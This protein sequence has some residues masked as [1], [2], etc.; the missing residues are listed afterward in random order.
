MFFRDDVRQNDI[1]SLL[2]L[3]KEK[4]IFCSLCNLLYCSCLVWFPLVL[5][6][7]VAANL[8]EVKTRNNTLLSVW[9]GVSGLL[10]VALCFAMSVDPSLRTNGQ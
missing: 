10:A 2:A 8:E 7:V 5:V 9:F 3:D 4:S 1:L 6:T